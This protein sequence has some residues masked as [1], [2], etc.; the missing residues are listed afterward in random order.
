VETYR[1]VP[2]IKRYFCEIYI[3]IYIYNCE[4]VGGSNDNKRCTVQNIKLMSITLNIT[5]EIVWSIRTSP[6]ISS[7]ISV[8]WFHCCIK[9][10]HAR[11]MDPMKLYVSLAED[12]DR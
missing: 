5:N 4:S 1:S 8:T 9:L 3:Y 12:K 7:F 2:Y 6:Q 10:I 11:I